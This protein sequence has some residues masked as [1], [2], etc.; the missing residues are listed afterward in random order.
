MSL[1]LV[2]TT[3]FIFTRTGPTLIPVRFPLFLEVRDTPLQLSIVGFQFL[4]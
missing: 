1:K 3:F 4:F 2:L